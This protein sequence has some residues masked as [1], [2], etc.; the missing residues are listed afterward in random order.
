MARLIAILF[1]TIFMTNI[2]I[3]SD[4][5]DKSIVQPPQVLVSNLSERLIE[6]L[7]QLKDSEQRKEQI[8]LIIS[9]TLLPHIDSQYAAYSVLGKHLKKSSKIQRSRFHLA[10]RE[11]LVTT[12]ANAL[13]QFS[14]QN[15]IVQPHKK[16][17]PTK[18][19]VTVKA[20]LVATD[21]PAVDIYFKL[22]KNQKTG[23]WKVYDFVAEGISLL[24]SKKKEFAGLLNASGIDETISFIEKQ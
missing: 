3:A 14:D 19:M 9:S 6:Q 5:I 13:A 17:S 11:H 10:F 16:L 21:A 8:E 7:T 1:F 24:Q 18:R 2:S 23:Q 12:Y 4:A 22:R 20:K 15:L